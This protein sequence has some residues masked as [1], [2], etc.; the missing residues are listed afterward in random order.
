MERNRD[1]VIS[2]VRQL[3]TEVHQGFH[4][5]CIPSHK[6]LKNG[7]VY[8]LADFSEEAVKTHKEIFDNPAVFPYPDFTK[9]FILHRDASYT[10][11]VAVLSQ[12]DTANNETPI[13]FCIRTL[14]KAE[15]PYSVTRNELL[16]LLDAAQH[17]RVY[18]YGRKL[19]ARTDHSSIL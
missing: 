6:R 18:L 19:V 17:F 5:D 1:Q 3:L 9:Q 10:G 13:A 8:P 15:R 12:I 2:G 7:E 11:S 4:Y 16:A 14:C